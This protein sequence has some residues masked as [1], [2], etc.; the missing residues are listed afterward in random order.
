MHLWVLLMFN[1]AD[2]DT[3]LVKKEYYTS[4]QECIQHAE[5]HQKKMVGDYSVLV[6][7]KLG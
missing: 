7:R 2:Y 5:V 1:C 3:C 4:E 6:C